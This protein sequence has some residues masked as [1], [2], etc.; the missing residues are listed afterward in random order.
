MDNKNIFINNDGDLKIS[1]VQAATWS[2]CFNDSEE[3]DFNIN[4]TNDND[5]VNNNN[6][7][8]EKADVLI[9]SRD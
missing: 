8:N 5:D 4:M 9:P 2:I 7:T 1:Q 3:E 6:N